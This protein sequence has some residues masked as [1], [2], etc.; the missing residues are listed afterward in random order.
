MINLQTLKKLMFILCTFVCVS[1]VSDHW[2]RTMWPAHCYRACLSRSQGGRVREERCFLPQQCPPPV[3]FYHPGS[4]G[5]RCKKVPR[6][7][8][9]RIHRP[10]QWVDGDTAN[11]SWKYLWVGFML[12]CLWDRFLQVFVSCSWCC[13]KWLWSWVSRSMSM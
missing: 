11:D 6:K 9:C 5:P 7:I 13:W 3:A 12:M 4:A 2:S 1:A 10:Y 8:L